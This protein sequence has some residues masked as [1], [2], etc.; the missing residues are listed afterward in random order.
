MNR[1]S[2]ESLELRQFL[3]VSP[4][5]SDGD[6][7]PTLVSTIVA[8]TE[9]T[10]T[11]V[12]LNEYAHQRFTAKL[13]EFHL[14]VSDLALSAVITWGDGTHSAGKIEGSYA[15]GDWYVEGTHTYQHTGTFKVN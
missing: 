15:T 1:F 9:P 2:L 5:S 14:K 4:L 3:I 6:P 10:P 13:G 11:G 8:P 12:H 7:S